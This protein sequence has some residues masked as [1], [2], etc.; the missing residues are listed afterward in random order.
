MLVKVIY[1]KNRTSA[2]ENSFCLWLQAAMLRWDFPVNFTWCKFS[3]NSTF[4]IMY[5]Y[6]S[7]IFLCSFWKFML[8]SFNIAMQKSVMSMNQLATDPNSFRLQ[9]HRWNQSNDRT[10]LMKG[11]QKPFSSSLDAWEAFLYRLFL[12]K[13]TRKSNFTRHRIPSTGDLHS[14]YIS[15]AACRYQMSTDRILNVNRFSSSRYDIKD[16][17]SRLYLIFF[18]VSWLKSHQK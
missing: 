5:C 8:W 11:L 17:R 18:D 9:Q 14:P 12:G 1:D 4:Q 2:E 6:D 16:I 13:R 3:W 7:N 10:R 15:V